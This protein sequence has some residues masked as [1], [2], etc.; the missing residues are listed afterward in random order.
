MCEDYQMTKRKL[1]I[2]PGDGIGPEAMA[3]VVK[4]ISHMNDNE[5]AGFETSQGLVRRLPWRRAIQHRFERF[6]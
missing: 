5:A 4:L 3:E 1:F 2:L 6:L